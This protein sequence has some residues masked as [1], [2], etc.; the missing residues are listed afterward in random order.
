MPRLKR[1]LF[2]VD[3]SQPCAR[4]AGAVA[5]LTKHFKASLTILHAAG[6]PLIPEITYPERLYS[7]LRKQIREAST[8]A[9]D[10]FMTRHFPSSDVDRVIEEGDAA[11]VIVDY[12]R[13]HKIDLIMMPTHGYSPF[14]RFLTGSVT[15]KVLH[16]S[17][18]PVWTFAHSRR[19]RSL[20]SAKIRNILCA[21]DSN[22][23]AVPVIRWAGWLGR[24]FQATVKLVHV[25][26]ALD[27]TSRN[28]GEVELRRYFIRRA[29]S[30]FEVLMDQAGYRN[31]LL[32]RGGDIPARL[33]ETAHQQHS[34][35][36]IVGRGHTRKA[37][38]RLRTHSL[39]II[40][41][42]PCPVISV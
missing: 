9:M 15:G 21:V 34:D 23:E 28:R 5:A 18:V 3:F 1:I 6:I 26:P 19:A 30:E 13:T 17:R 12:A 7:A 35:L 14:R 27:E 2:P 16:D 37:L 24:H 20:A 22:N 25:I 11:E 33:A 38:G 40:R 36:L 42:S 10:R 39:S 4:A 31:E 41:E 8:Q 32:L 29:Q